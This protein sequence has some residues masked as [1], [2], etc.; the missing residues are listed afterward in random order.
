MSIAQTRID[1]ADALTGLGLEGHPVPPD[2]FQPGQG[3]AVW[4]SAVPMAGGA[5][6]TWD[7]FV[8]LPGGTDADAIAEADKWTPVVVD[9]LLEMGVIVI[10]EP[11]T[12][13]DNVAPALRF[14]LTTL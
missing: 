10:F 7:V 6:I 11:V 8:T 2:V 1:I 5:E 3:W 14:A 12:L 4:R 9:A 13:G